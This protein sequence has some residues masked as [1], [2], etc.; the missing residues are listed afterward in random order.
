MKLSKTARAGWL[1]IFRGILLAATLELPWPRSLNWLW[2]AFDW[3]SAVMVVGGAATLMVYGL[4]NAWWLCEWALTDDPLHGPGREERLAA[5]REH[6]RMITVHAGPEARARSWAGAVWEAQRAG[7]FSLN[8]V[9]HPGAVTMRYAGPPPVYTP[10]GGIDMVITVEL[11]A[12]A[13]IGPCRCGRQGCR[14]G[15]DT[16]RV[17]SDECDECGEPMDIAW[18]RPGTARVCRPCLTH[19]MPGYRPY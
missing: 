19:G 8:G 18:V 5:A 13:R 12:E 17:V 2:T 9:R 15:G 14:P 11:R 16:A 4:L 7:T 1:N 6:Q 10:P 3:G